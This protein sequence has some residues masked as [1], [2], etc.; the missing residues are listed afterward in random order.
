MKG[1]ETYDQKKQYHKGWVQEYLGDKNNR[2]NEKRTKNITVGGRG[3]VVSVKTLL[4]PI[5][6]G[7][8][9]RQAAQD[10]QLREPS[11]LY[12]SHFAVKNDDI[13]SAIAIFGTYGKD[14]RPEKTVKTIEAR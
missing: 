9:V 6:R 1:I 14:K 2:C 11:V 12:G 4:G 13:P 5:A 3:L 10:Y 8:K 7:R